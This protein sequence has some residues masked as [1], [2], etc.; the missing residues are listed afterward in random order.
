MFQGLGSKIHL[1]LSARLCGSEWCLL[2]LQTRAGCHR[3]WFPSIVGTLWCAWGHPS[4]WDSLWDCQGTGWLAA[5][6]LLTWLTVTFPT[7]L[8]KLMI[9]PFKALLTYGCRTR[10]HGDVAY[11][12]GERRNS[13]RLYHNVDT[14]GKEKETELYIYST[15]PCKDCNESMVWIHVVCYLHL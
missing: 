10:L 4:Q 12:S 8:S 2:L 6:N 14:K 11:D 5:A 9:K 1:S 7:V 13:G 15:F 3:N